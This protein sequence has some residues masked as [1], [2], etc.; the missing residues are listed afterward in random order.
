MKS[1]LIGDNEIGSGRTY[2]IAEIGSNHTRDLEIA[3]ATIDAAVAAGVDA[4]KF[5]SLQLNEL[6]INPSENISELHRKIDLPEE[7]HKP[8]MEYCNRKGVHFFSAPTYLTSV[9]ILEETG[10]LLY[11]L[12][13]AQ[14]G[15]FPQI[16]RKVARIGK[17]VIISTGLVTEDSLAEVVEVFRQEGNDKLIILH[18]NSIY[19]APYDRISLPLIERYRE[20][21]QVLT[22]FSDHTEDHTAAIAA[23]T[24]G[25]CVLEKHFTLSR[26]LP[27]PDAPFALE[28]DEMKNY[29]DE[30]R[31]TEAAL[32]FIPRDNIQ[33]EESAFKQRILYR[34][35]LKSPISKG[36][37][38]TSD[39][40]N[41]LRTDQG[42]D[43]RD[44]DKAGNKGIALRDL[45]A[46]LIPSDAIQL[47]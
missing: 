46:G 45:E 39:M 4:V 3:Y 23:I 14:I 30:I 1:I 2:I 10:V 7:W 35:V 34:L 25:A 17:P 5:Q 24:K 20:R 18:C 11:K 31:K 38:I 6:Y 27:T 44:F 36:E 21:F 15:T 16:V 43:A 42:I 37:V 28:P 19:P 32:K 47:I 40:V 29:V 41:F 22:G 33:P 8:L 12:A 13:S 9:D 26:L